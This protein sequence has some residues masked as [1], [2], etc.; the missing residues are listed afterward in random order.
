M[1]GVGEAVG[2]GV[3]PGGGGAQGGVGLAG[4]NEGVLDADVQRLP[5][6][7]EPDAAAG[8][9]RGGLLELGQTEEVAVEGSGGGLA[10]RRGGD[11]GV[12]EADDR[13]RAHDGGVRGWE[14]RLRELAEEHALYEEAVGRLRAL[15]VLLAAEEHAPTPIR[16]PAQAVDAHVADSL[17][18]LAVVG[19][20]RHIADLGSGAGFPGLVLAAARPGASVILVESVGRKAAWLERATATLGLDNVQVRGERVEAW[21]PDGRI[22]LV[23]AR[24]LASLPVL[25]EYAAPLL[26]P[27][28][29]LVAWKGDPDPAE[30]ADGRAAAAA[31]GLE[32][33]AVVPVQPFPG[34]RDRR[35]YVYAKVA[36]TPPGYPRRAGAAAKRP[37]GV[38]DRHRR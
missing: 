11:L 15:L 22:D 16:E 14:R 27:G 31:L 19:A 13:H 2:E 6:A 18:G 28:G 4:G 9:E 5:A 20:P 32:E 3:E 12:V 29:R 23:T 30:E 24:A 33:S 25:V 37:L 21:R 26:A 10:T 38:S 35:L 8:L 36:E 1:A 7:G 34:V 17:S